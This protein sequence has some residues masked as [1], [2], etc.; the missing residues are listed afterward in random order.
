MSELYLIDGSGYIF[1]AYFALNRDRGAR[2]SMPDGTPTGAVY[3]FNQMLMKL[4]KDVRAHKD[5]LVGMAFDSAKPN[6]RHQIYKE[7]KAHR[8]EPPDDLKPQFAMIHDLVKAWDMPLLLEDGYEADDVLATLA[9]AG[10]AKGHH[11][12]VVTGDKDLMQLVQDGISLYDPMRDAHYERAQVKD[13]MGV[14]PEQIVDYLAL[15]GDAVDNVPGVPKIGPKTAC[16]LLAEFKSL[17]G[18]YANLPNV[19]KNAARLTLEEHRDDAFLSQKLCTLAFD[20][21]VALEE[22]K[23]RFVPPQREKIEP[24]FT[25][26]AFSP[27]TLAQTLA[28]ADRDH[29]PPPEGAEPAVAAPRVETLSSDNYRVVTT[30]DALAV[31][32]ADV[33]AAGTVAL[34]LETDA[35][36][37][38]ARTLIGL[39]VAT[40]PGIAAYI[41]LTHHYLGVPAQLTLAQVR[42]V[43]GAALR[44]TRYVAH[45]AKLLQH[46]AARLDFPLGSASDDISLL[47]YV[48]EP[49]RENH[50][51][52]LLSRFFLGHEMMPAETFAGK[53]RAPKTMADAEV[54]RAGRAMSERVDVILRLAPPLAAKLSVGETA[55][56]REVELPLVSVLQRIEAHGIKISPVRLAELASELHTRI[57]AV[58]KE[59][60]AIAGMEI[61]LGSPK[62]LGTL[63]FDKLSLPVMKKTKSGA[64]TDQSVLEQL[65]ELHPVPAKIL[66][67]RQLQRLLS[68]YVEALPPIMDTEGRVHTTFNQALAATGR[69]SSADPNLQNIPVRTD[70]GRRIR[71]AFIAPPGSK[72]ISA[73]YSQVELR[74]LA[75]MSG[76]AALIDA[77]QRG[78]DIHERTAQLL[79][80]VEPEGVTPDMRRRAKTLN[81]GLLYGLSPFRLAR[82]EDISMAD[83]K[84]FIDAY[85]NAYPSVR[86]FISET[87]KT[88]RE[89]GYVET[90]FG[91]RRYLPDLRSKAQNMRQAA[92]RI[93]TNSPIQGSAADIIK[94][95]MINLQRRLDAEG[96]GARLLLQ[97]HDEL[98]LESPESETEAAVAVV[99]AEMERAHPLRVPL[100]VETSV[101]DDW[102]LGA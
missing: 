53:P 77:F 80:H 37:M 29:A 71:G 45:D 46:A 10:K 28:L 68:T 1:R 27:G 74:V 22:D 94:V 31:L 49:G 59:I 38:Q 23:L 96:S 39:S 24:L 40:A 21:P 8:P 61:N 70:L 58:A 44:E 78:Q 26:L 76:D 79:F 100:V 4:M 90:M 99:K 57:D 11:V 87:L 97:V 101:S 88:A 42:E 54:E 20:V 48:L 67:H 86:G 41:P 17:A 55:L 33:R 66:E 2:M 75:H 13:K 85:F 95:A 9:M 73:D 34:F 35:P 62:Q 82:E 5:T 36:G 14:Y 16:E 51:L 102:N 92:E 7:Y 25:R 50:S 15:V 89:Q 69:L 98:V 72:L 56:Y 81:F 43:L 30:A 12:T 93:A 83:A 52:V 91:R 18:I 19:R 64:S 32:A 84:A 63:L 3:V 47:S 60:F 65:A 6:F